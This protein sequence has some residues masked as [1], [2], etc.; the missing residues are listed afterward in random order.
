MLKNCYDLPGQ[1]NDCYKKVLI[2]FFIGDLIY[3]LDLDHITFHDF[4]KKIK[5]HRPYNM[6]LAKFSTMSEVSYKDINSAVT[7]VFNN[8]E[9]GN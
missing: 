1:I 8:I 5:E 4:S 6:I 9:L 2:G 7:T 3:S